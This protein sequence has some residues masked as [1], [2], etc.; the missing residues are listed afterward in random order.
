MASTFICVLF[1]VKHDKDLSYCFNCLFSQLISDLGKVT[2]LKFAY[3][4]R[5]IRLKKKYNEPLEYVDPVLTFIKIIL[6]VF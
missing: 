5:F 4:M 2:A 1:S 6:N 3:Q